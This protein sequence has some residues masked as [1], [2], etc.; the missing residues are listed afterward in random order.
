ML[1]REAIR[2]CSVRFLPSKHTFQ[3]C[4]RGLLTDSYAHHL[5]PVLKTFCPITQG[6]NEREQ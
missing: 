2:Y 6:Q 3:G 5:E 1:R 4:L